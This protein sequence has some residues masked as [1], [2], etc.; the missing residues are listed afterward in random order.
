MFHIKQNYQTV[1]RDI[2]RILCECFE[3]GFVCV[4]ASASIAVNENTDA[5]TFLIN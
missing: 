3:T 1:N 2:K 4:S 5:T